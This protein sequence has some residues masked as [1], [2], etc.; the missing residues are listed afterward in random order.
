MSDILRECSQYF[1]SIRN[2]LDEFLMFFC[3][4]SPGFSH[5]LTDFS[6]AEVGDAKT[7]PAVEI[8]FGTEVAERVEMWRSGGSRGLRLGG[9]FKHVLFSPLFGEDFQFANIFQM[10][11]NHQLVDYFFFN[12]TVI[13][14]IIVDG[15]LWIFASHQICQHMHEVCSSLGSVHFFWWSSNKQN[16]QIPGRSWSPCAFSFAAFCFLKT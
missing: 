12:N 5:I 9:G 13:V 2:H 14:V 4:V 16:M 8:C 10:G 7:W 11:W 6:Q 1:A 3:E 15:L